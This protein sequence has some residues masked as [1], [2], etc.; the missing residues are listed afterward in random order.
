M[1]TDITHDDLQ[2][3]SELANS[4]RLGLPGKIIPDFYERRLK[5]LGL[6]DERA[7]LELL[8]D[9]PGELVL[10]TA[11]RRLLEREYTRT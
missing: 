4:K 2:W 11:G 5:A 8:E 6:I 10:T 9:E 1:A 7:A 3:L